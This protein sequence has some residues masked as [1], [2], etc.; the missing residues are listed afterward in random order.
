MERRATL[1]A[2]GSD[3]GV[4]FGQFGHRIDHRTYVEFDETLRS[5]ERKAMK[6]VDRGIRRQRPDSACLGEI[7][8]KER[9]ATCLR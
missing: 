6:H 7:G 5:F 1:P 4:P 3:K 2:A 8:D 9:F